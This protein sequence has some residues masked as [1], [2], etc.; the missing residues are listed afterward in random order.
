MVYFGVHAGVVAKGDRTVVIPGTSGSG[1]S[2]L[3]A[4]CIRGGF[5]YLSDEALCVDYD[6]GLIVPYPKPLS[7]S[8]RSLGV[9][10]VDLPELV[11]LGGTKTPIG[12]E[13]LG[14]SLA[15]GPSRLSDFISFERRPG[16]AH[17][18][19]AP[20]SVVIAGLLKYSFNHYKRP[21]DAFLLTSE[22]ARQCR[23]WALGF[24]DPIEAAALLGSVISR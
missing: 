24:D 3:V 8:G 21:A 17:I 14:G 20:A 16:E 15:E 11:E 4:A 12:P 2:T 23:G 18:Q 1:K 22:L 5:S 6:T 19:P 13:A 9:L 7:L 10:G